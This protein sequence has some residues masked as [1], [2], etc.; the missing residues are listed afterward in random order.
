MPCSFGLNVIPNATFDEVREGKVKI[1][2]ILL[3]GGTGARPW[4]ASDGLKDF[5]RWAARDDSVEWVL[6]GEL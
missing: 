3:P 5:V 6:T 1:D 2:A 4:N